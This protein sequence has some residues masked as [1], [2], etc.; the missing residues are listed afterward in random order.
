MVHEATNTSVL[1]LTDPK[2]RYQQSD[3]LQVVVSA[4]SRPRNLCD[5]LKRKVAEGICKARA[6]GRRE[7]AGSGGSVAA[8]H[9]GLSTPSIT[10]HGCNSL[11]GPTAIGQFYCRSSST[12][13]GTAQCSCDYLL[14]IP[15]FLFL[16]KGTHEVHRSSEHRKIVK[17]F[18]I[19]IYLTRAA[20]HF[21]CYFRLGV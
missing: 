19:M 1:S 16:G 7:E 20:K 4:L 18:A 3:M 10:R 14:T 2:K 17:G 15:C 8:G 13:Q 11:L 5:N 9:R 12:F 21:N 6:F